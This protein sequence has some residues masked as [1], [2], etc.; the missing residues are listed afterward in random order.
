MRKPRHQKFKLLAQGTQLVSGRVRVFVPKA[1][2][3]PYETIRRIG[4]DYSQ[5][6]SGLYREYPK[7][8]PLR[9]ILQ[10]QISEALEELKSWS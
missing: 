4:E 7:N 9:T 10:M 3:L 2:L 8:N 6:H 1:M 5:G